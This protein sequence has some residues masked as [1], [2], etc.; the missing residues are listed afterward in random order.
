MI[1]KEENIE[2]KSKRIWIL[3]HP[4]KALFLTLG[5]LAILCFGFLWWV[6]YELLG[7]HP[8]NGWHRGMTVEEKILM[9]LEHANSSNALS[10]ESTAS[11]TGVT[12][13]GLNR[14]VPYKNA[15]TILR[16]QPDCCHVYESTSA[17]T[18]NPKEVDKTLRGDEGTVVLRYMGK[19]RT[20]SG[21]I[22]I[23][24]VFHY[25]DLNQCKRHN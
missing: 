3:R 17:L 21:G 8:C 14:Q 6:S 23:A 18:E 20:R 22:H 15:E 13:R 9:V 16:E 25:L 12:H 19:Q 24:R 11:D 1:K 7:S 5:V 10:F 4:F 2:K